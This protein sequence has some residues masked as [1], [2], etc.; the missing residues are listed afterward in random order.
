MLIRPSPVKRL[1][2]INKTAHELLVDYVRAVT[3]LQPQPLAQPVCRDPDDDEVLG[4]CRTWGV[5]SENRPQQRQFLPDLQA[6]S[7]AMG[8]KDG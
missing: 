6:H 3:V 2:L 7:P 1:K 5:E 8:Q 4:A